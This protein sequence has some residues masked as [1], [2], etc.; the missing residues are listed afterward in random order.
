MCLTSDVDAL[1]D[2]ELA[3]PQVV[4][5]GLKVLGAAVDEEGA[6]LVPR[7]APH[8]CSRDNNNNNGAACWSAG[9]HTTHLHGCVS[10]TVF[11]QNVSD[12]SSK[13]ICH[14]QVFPLKGVKIRSRTS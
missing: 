2:D 10:G 7:V 3:V 11:P 6:A 5:D 4:E 9:F 13:S 1:V 8:I 14:F 12:D